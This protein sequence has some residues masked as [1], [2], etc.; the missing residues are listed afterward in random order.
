MVENAEAT[1]IQQVIIGRRECYRP[2]VE[3]YQK[4]IYLLACSMLGNAAEAQDITQE[5]F[6]LAYKNLRDLKDRGKYGSWLYGIT[7]NL[8]YAA[9]RRKR[10]EPESLEELAPQDAPSNVIPMWPADEEGTDL[11]SEL[12]SKLESLPDKY[13]VLLN[14]KYL[15]DCSYQE[16]SE[17]LDLPVDL[18]RSR[19][20][21]GRR[22]LREGVQ[23]TRSLEHEG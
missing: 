9:L 22:M 20:F 16:I 13:R 17:M 14:L 21:E 10:I 8:C 2:L 19:L 7:R 11:R 3:K 6:L 15:D 4:K 18:V 1:M 12:L 23:K 5:A